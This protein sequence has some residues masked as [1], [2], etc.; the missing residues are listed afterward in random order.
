MVCPLCGRNEEADIVEA[1]QRLNNMSTTRKGK[2]DGRMM[3]GVI[4]K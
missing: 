3:R 4:L 1:E 2:N